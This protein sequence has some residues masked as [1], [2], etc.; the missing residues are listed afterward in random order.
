M[1]DQRL[2][3]MQRI[4]KALVS[5]REHDSLGPSNL[6]TTFLEIYILCGQ[7]QLAI[8]H[9]ENT[10]PGAKI[11]VS[12]IRRVAHNMGLVNPDIESAIQVGFSDALEMT[13]AEAEELF[14]VYPFEQNH[15]R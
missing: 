9:P 4:D 11:A 2:E 8:R 5:C 7:L 1:N 14:S 13:D 15:D 3:A 10:G 6:Q 12:F